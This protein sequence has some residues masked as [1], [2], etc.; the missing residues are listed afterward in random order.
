MDPDTKIRVFSKKLYIKSI[1][2][3]DIYVIQL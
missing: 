3:I 2:T 1:I